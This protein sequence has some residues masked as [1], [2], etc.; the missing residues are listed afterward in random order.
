MTISSLRPCGRRP[1]V[2][3]S[4]RTRAATAV[5]AVSALFLTACGDDSA[6]EPAPG[7]GSEE[8]A[9][10]FGELTVQLSWIKNAEFAGEFFADSRGYF[11]DAGFGEPDLFTA[12][13]SQGAHPVDR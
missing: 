13:P 9:A 1:A 2:S 4:A 11:A 7:S 5:C 12:H 3:R 6:E 8:G 10:D